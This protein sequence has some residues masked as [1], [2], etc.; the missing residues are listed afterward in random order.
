[1]P[2]IARRCARGA[3]FEYDY[4]VQGR[5]A[6]RGGKILGSGKRPSDLRDP[7]FLRPPSREAFV[8]GYEE[9]AET[10]PGITRD[11]ARGRLQEGQRVFPSLSALGEHDIKSAWSA[12]LLH[13]R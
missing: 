9:T 8:I 2:G 6:G 13:P 4:V 10:S 7:C 12:S 3:I 11:V 5:I 1:M